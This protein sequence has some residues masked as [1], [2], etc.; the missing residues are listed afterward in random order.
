MRSHARCSFLALLTGVLIVLAA[1]VAAQAAG[2]GVE[3]FFASN[4]GKG[5]ET[6]VEAEKFEKCGK[7]AKEATTLKEAEEEAYTVAGGHP[8]FGVT[9]FR[10]NT[11]EI[12]AGVRAPLESVK[13]LRTDVA[14][15]VVTNPEAVSKC[16]LKDFESTLVEPTH[17]FYL[18]SKC[19]ATSVIGE[20]IVLTVVP[21]GG[22]KFA[23]VPLAGKVYNLEQPSGLSSDFG[24]AL[25]VKALTEGAPLFSHTYIKGGVEW[26]S[27]YHDYFT[28][29]N[30]TPGLIESR[31][32]F[33]GRHNGPKQEEENS[34]FLRNPSK[35]TKPNSPE[36]TTKVSMEGYNG[37]HAEKSYATLLGSVKC[38][39]EPFGPGFEVKPELATS[40][41]PDGITTE[42]TQTHPAKSSET[43]SS[44][45]QTAGLT[46]PPGMT[47]NPSAGA[48]L[49]GC[50][51]A[52]IG[53]E[54]LSPNV[55]CPGGSRIGTVNIEVPTLPPESLKGSIYVGK[56][57]S[58]PI[59][60]P[61]YTIYID[62]ES[63]RYNVKVRLKGLVTPDPVTGQ[64]RA[65]FT[66]NPPAPFNDVILHFRGGAFA[67]LANP[68]VCGPATTE[69]GLVGFS[70]AAATRLSS[71][72][73]EGCT[74]TPPPFAPTQATNAEPAQ[75]GGSSTFALNVERPE[76][77]QYLAKLRDVLPPGLLGLIP[78][79][80]Q[81]G[82]PQAN[83][84]TCTS[85]SQIGT[86]TVASGS[87]T[88]Y[89]FS[90]RVYL[91]GPYEGAPF[92]LSIVVPAVAG[93]FN[94][95]NVVARASIN[96]NQT[97][98]QVIATDNNVPMIV[99]GVPIRLRSL[100]IS[101]NRQ[102][103]ERNPTNCTTPLFTES[104]FTGSLGGVAA[105]KTA[106]PVEGCSGLSF[107]PTFKATTS[108][109]TSKNNGA[110]LETTINQPAGGASIKSVLVTLPK[111][112]PSRLSTLQKACPE[113]TF[114][115]N[116]YSCPAG[117]LVGSARAN[118]PVLPG[119]LQGPAYLVSHGGAAFPDLDLVFEA[120][121]VR[122]IVVGNTD[123]KNGITTTNFAASPDAPVSSITLLL[124]T[125]P[126]SALT[127]YGDVCKSPLYMPTTIT[128][129]NGKIFKQ[130]TKINVTNCGVKV[131][132]QKVIGN[133][134]Y[135]TVRTFAP[136]RIS[137]S[138]SNVS[139]VVRHLNSAQSGTSLKVSLNGSRRKPLR[140]KIRVGFVPKS[141]SFGNSV[142]YATVVFR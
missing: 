53:L 106:F 42:L 5:G 3:K 87:G 6:K 24:V 124:P 69:I 52:Q 4:C 46:L 98:A 57:A 26:L 136:G 72:T 11:A 16:S 116:P 28:I 51:P 103:F 34:G 77:N 2:F 64:L 113:A 91:T 10:L 129:Q 107:A 17:G 117:S 31:L 62:A 39:E 86:A 38:N 8:P 131:V 45:V 14:P 127:A 76:G 134:A 19:P 119:K 128:A 122:V 43:D 47:M 104:T 135:L 37:E 93:P 109:K 114:A 88:P 102:G 32:V 18:E 82:E 118:T 110:S 7:V 56:P 89:T 95:G 92:G 140:V 115:A 61:P 138:G 22:G 44:D 12:E 105:A 41:A 9:D 120:N 130:N 66:E 48:G 13:N 84:G 71:F 112:L 40:D 33:Y 30:I 55:S 111:T 63:A 36:T 139:T 78:T 123:I 65:T 74:S 141:K 68:L 85:A 97:T 80:T 20:N 83:A 70:G 90:G 126:H 50:T 81:C 1:P 60:G 23:D 58:T 100:T 25:D 94:L 67:P 79:V 101:I 29:S 137:G 73:T 35:C 96:V 75:G 142:A 133:T 125:G 121:G 27:D 15:G 59:E 49:E 99:K 54:P 132:G 108:A 21:I